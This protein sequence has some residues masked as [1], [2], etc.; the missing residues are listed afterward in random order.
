METD[1]AGAGGAGGVARGV[2]IADLLRARSALD[3]GIRQEYARIDVGRS[4]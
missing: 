4:P 2:G 3:E 1:E